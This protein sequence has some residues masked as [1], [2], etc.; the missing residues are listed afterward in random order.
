MSQ[1]PAQGG[2][3]GA[4]ILAECCGSRHDGSGSK[5]VCWTRY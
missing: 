1:S 2:E 5:L 3:G 4:G